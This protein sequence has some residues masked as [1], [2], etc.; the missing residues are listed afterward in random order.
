[1][2]A[3]AQRLR[4][5]AA[6]EGNSDLGREMRRIAEDMDKAAA[7]LERSADKPPKS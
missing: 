4:Q 5:I 2:R 7:E 3:G 1:M 6:S